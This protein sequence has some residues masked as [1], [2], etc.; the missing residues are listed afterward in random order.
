MAFDYKL[1]TLEDIEMYQFYE[2]ICDGDS[3]KIIAI[4]KRSEKNGKRN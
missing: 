2:F 3:K 1:L 4:P